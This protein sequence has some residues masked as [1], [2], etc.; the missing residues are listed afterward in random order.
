MSII[1]VFVAIIVLGTLRDLGALLGFGGP[2]VTY[3]NVVEVS[4][5]YTLYTYV[6]S[7]CSMKSILVIG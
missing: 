1:L 3:S 2:V 4:P 7:D 5:G 6:Y